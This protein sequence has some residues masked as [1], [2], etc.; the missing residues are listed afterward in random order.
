MRFLYFADQMDDWV[1]D[2][3]VEFTEAN[4]QGPYTAGG[5]AWTKGSTVYSNNYADQTY[6]TGLKVVFTPAVIPHDLVA[7]S[8]S[9]SAVPTNATS[10]IR[11]AVTNK[12]TTAESFSV[13][14]SNLTAS[15]LIGSQTVSSLPG[16]T[17]TNVPFLWNTAGLLGAYTLQAAAGPVSGE[18]STN[19]NVISSSVSV[20]FIPHDLAVIRLTPTLVPP[21]TNV[22][23]TVTVTNKSI[24]TETF[25]G[26]R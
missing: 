22:T 26:S 25:S 16:N 8:I 2:P 23:M 24:S 3:E 9:P 11:V 14:L 1:T 5:L 15:T 20:Q 18:T 6:I 7:L 4:A 13:V 17:L 10:T 19:D 21:N 12:T